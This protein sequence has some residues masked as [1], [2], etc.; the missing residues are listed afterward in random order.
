MR[1]VDV[2][3]TTQWRNKRE[4]ADR[5][6]TTTRTVEQ[7]IE[8][9]RKLG[10]LPIMSTQDGYRLATSPDEY[11]ANVA[12]RRKRALV[13]LITVRGEREYLNAWRERLNPRPVAPP[14]APQPSQEALPWA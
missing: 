6:N 14:Q 5:L 3:S 13:Q 9:A 11:E 1:L 4:L 12:L 8:R 10:Q 7:M 2:L